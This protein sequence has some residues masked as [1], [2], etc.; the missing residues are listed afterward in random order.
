MLTKEQV[1]EIKARAE[2][3]SSG[4]WAEH[5]AWQSRGLVMA[6]G[7]VRKCNNIKPSDVTFIAAARADVPALCETIDG[8]RKLLQAL[9]ESCH[10]DCFDCE[11]FQEE[12]G[13][14]GA[15]LSAKAA[16]E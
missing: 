15:G 4:P 10:E 1:A 6:D 2:K 16:L 14:C 11:F 13:R 5:N 12:A 7:K 9:S 3:A 8:L